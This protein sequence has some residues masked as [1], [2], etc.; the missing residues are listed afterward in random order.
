[1]KL[2]LKWKF[3][4]LIIPIVLMLIYIIDG[5]MNSRNPVTVKHLTYRNYKIGYIQYRKGEKDLYPGHA[6]YNEDLFKQANL[7]LANKLLDEYLQT[8]DTTLPN[9]ITRITNLYNLNYTISNFKFEE[10][11][12]DRKN[13][14]DT[15]IIID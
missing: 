2:G 15:T 9:E 4:I 3:L 12:R 1:M 10:I 11:L 6:I 5:I 14:L 13:I 8:N 7:I